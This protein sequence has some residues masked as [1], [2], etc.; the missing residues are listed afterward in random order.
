[1]AA[2]PGAGLLR[3]LPEV[4]VDTEPALRPVV[5]AQLTLH[6]FRVHVP[7]GDAEGALTDAGAGAA[8]LTQVSAGAEDLARI[9]RLRHGAPDAPMLAVVCDD[10]SPASLS[11]LASHR[12]DFVRRAVIADELHL[13][14]QHLAMRSGDRVRT[15]PGLADLSL[16]P[17]TQRAWWKGRSVE[18]TL[19]EA[20][21][22]DVLASRSGEALER[23]ELLALVWDDTDGRSRRNV[24]EVYVNYLRQKLDRIGCA[25]VVRTVRG[26]GYMASGDGGA[27]NY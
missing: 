6:G 23:R 10:M 9:D 13:R 11:V 17:A 25:D 16:E 3:R 19:R 7:A 12:V 1:M 21:L 14:I 26:V 27:R 18:L 15:Y 24:V 4:V 5:C 8:L 2:D 22:L 20:R